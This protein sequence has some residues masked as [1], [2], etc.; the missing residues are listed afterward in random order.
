M[1][2]PQFLVLCSL[3]VA[4][5]SLVVHIQL[6]EQDPLPSRDPARVSSVT[7]KVAT[8]RAERRISL[9]RPP[10]VDNVASTLTVRATEPHPDHPEVADPRA[11]RVETRAREHLA[12]LD[13]T[14]KLSKDQQRRIFPILARNDPEFQP[15]MTISSESP[16]LDSGGAYVGSG[17]ARAPA[18][19]P[20][21]TVDRG[22]QKGP[23]SIERPTHPASNVPGRTP[24]NVPGR[25]P[26]SVPGNVPGKEASLL[27]PNE[28]ATLDTTDPSEPIMME[29]TP[30]QQTVYE[31][32]LID[33]GLWWSDIIGQI[34]SE[35]NRSRLD[36]EVLEDEGAGENLFDLIGH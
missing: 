4:I 23:A 1:K 19:G 27:R 25:T 20:L 26:D 10:A 8:S 2:K 31:D 5:I 11:S 30:E 28:L 24:D 9:P 3:T 12:R 21:D 14:L 15:S 35:Y 16:R 17:P 32:A 6:Q 7:G 34:E 13:E 29:L 36:P 22:G 18:S 33:E